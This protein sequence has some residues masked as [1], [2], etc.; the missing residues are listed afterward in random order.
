MRF[1]YFKT[2]ILVRKYNL[3]FFKPVVDELEDKV[4]VTR[5]QQHTLNQQ[6]DFTIEEC[7]R[8]ISTPGKN[9]KEIETC[10]Q[11]INEIRQRVTVVFNILQNSQDRLIILHNKIEAKR[12]QLLQ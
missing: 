8:L 10:A 6:L 2:I 3:R 11:K 9:T 4:K 7:Q 5:L 12:R 1:F